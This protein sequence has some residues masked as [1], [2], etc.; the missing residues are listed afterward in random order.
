MLLIQKKFSP[1]AK[2]KLISFLFILAHEKIVEL[3][4]RNGAII[5]AQN[6]YRQTPLHLAVRNGSDMIFFLKKVRKI[7]REK[8][9]PNTHLNNLG[10]EKITDL[11][12]EKKAKVNIVDENGHTVLHIAAENGSI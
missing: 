7:K 9:I 12:L 2:K 3:L 10:H 4:L 1:E 6:R 8:L 11:L 5:N